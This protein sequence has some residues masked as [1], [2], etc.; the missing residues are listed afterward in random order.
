MQN[1]VQEPQGKKAHGKPKQTWENNIKVNHINMVCR[2][3]LD[4]NGSW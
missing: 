1:F 3:E 4:S 2:C